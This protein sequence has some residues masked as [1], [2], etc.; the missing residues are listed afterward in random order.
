MFNRTDAVRVVLRTLTLKYCGKNSWWRVFGSPE[1]LFMSHVTST[2]YV[3]TSELSCASENAAYISVS[4]CDRST[5]SAAA[6]YAVNATEQW[7]SFRN[8]IASLADLLPSSEADSGEILSDIIGTEDYRQAFTNIL[9]EPAGMRGA[10]G[11]IWDSGANG[12]WWLLN[13]LG[14]LSWC[15]FPL[16][17]IRPILRGR[18]EADDRRLQ[19]RKLEATSLD[20]NK[21]LW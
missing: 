2:N 21:D 16:W 20:E 5:E 12:D 10:S 9:E 1:L 8:V 17:P 18:G 11:L 15:I 14:Y 7:K 6:K 13:C 3:V 19:T 4:A